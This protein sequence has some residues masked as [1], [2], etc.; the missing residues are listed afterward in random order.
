MAPCPNWGEVACAPKKEKSEKSELSVN[1][2]ELTSHG[3]VQGKEQELKEQELKRTV[4]DESST[5]HFI[6]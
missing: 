3:K 6:I 2:G 5:C 1:K 4:A